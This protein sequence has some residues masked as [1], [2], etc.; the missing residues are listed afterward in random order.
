MK[1]VNCGYSMLLHKPRDWERKM[2]YRGYVQMN[3]EHGTF[4]DKVL[5]EEC[6]KAYQK[7]HRELD[8]KFGLI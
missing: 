8:K 4:L 3:P 7:K 6:Y 5:C 2:G 1:C